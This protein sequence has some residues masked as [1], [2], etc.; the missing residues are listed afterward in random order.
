M[1]DREKPP[2][3]DQLDAK[4][5]EARERLASGADRKLRRNGPG[6]TMTGLGL[7][8]RVGTEL[9]A[10]IAV[11]AGVGYLLDRWWGTGP[12]MMVV[13]F[14]LGSAAGILNVYRAMG[15]LSGRSNNDRT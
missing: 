2:S 5:R 13:F 3:L 9:V 11:G 10:G 14:F 12:W 4:L 8:F 1:S 15:D 6:P 7:A